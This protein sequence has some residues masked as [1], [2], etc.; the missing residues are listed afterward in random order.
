MPFARTGHTIVTKPP[1]PAKDQL[2]HWVQRLS[3]HEMPAFAHTARLIAGEA[4]REDRSAAEL[5]RVILQDAS[6][7]TRLLRVANS[8]VYNPGR[9]SINTV[10][11]AIVVLGFDTVRNLCLSIAIIDTLVEGENRDRVLKEMAQSFHAAVQARSLA[12]K[13][14]DKSPEEI[15]IAALLYHLG[16][17]AFWCFAEQVDPAAN[18]ELQRAMDSEHPDMSALERRVLGFTLE[19]LTL[20]LN[21]EWHLSNLLDSALGEKPGHDP[22]ASNIH[23]GHEIAAQAWAGWESRDMGKLLERTAES[24]YLSREQTVQLVHENAR[25]AAATMANLGARKAGALIPRPEDMRESDTEALSAEQ[26]KRERFLKPDRDLQL[27]ILGE[28]SQLLAEENPA[29]NL[30]LE[31]VLEGIYRGVGMDRTLIAVLS[32]D[33]KSIRAKQTLG[34]DRQELEQMFHFKVSSPPQNVVDYVIENRRPLWVSQPP[35]SA[36]NDLLT[37]EIQRLTEGAAFFVMP[38]EIQNKAIGVLY[39]DRRPSH[40]DLDENSFS[41]FRLFGQQANLGLSYL[42]GR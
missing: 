21:R 3:E 20:A 9:G 6:M 42:K 10:S 39:A 7:T 37:P 2:A 38:L 16:R 5:A 24:L 13:R 33:R 29:I 1:K 25:D 14:R 32:T 18:R 28:L 4:A 19:E 8:I 12:E 31:M 11:R 30:L 36:V 35:Q 34:W 15:F 22:R 27:S 17:M 26:P 40:R 41:G 23:L